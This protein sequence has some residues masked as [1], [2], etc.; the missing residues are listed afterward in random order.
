MV[1][2]FYFFLPIFLI[3]FLLFEGNAEF[4]GELIAIPWARIRSH[5]ANPKTQSV[6]FK[7]KLPDATEESIFVFQTPKF[8]TITALFTKYMYMRSDALFPARWP[9]L[10]YDSVDK[11]ELNKSGLHVSPRRDVPK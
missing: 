4:L 1:I 7:A 2:A 11:P 6:T 5:G 9:P 3:C 10:R 8:E